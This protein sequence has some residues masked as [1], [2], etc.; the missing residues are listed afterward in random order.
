M[1]RMPL[2][3]G[4]GANMADIGKAYVQIEPTAKGISKKIEGEFSSVG[5]SS[6]AAFSGGFGKVIGG[7]GKVAA[8]AVAAGAGAMGALVTSATKNFGDYEQLVGGVETLFKGS[9]D[10]V[11]ANADRAFASA[12]MSANEYMET[13]TSF[14]ASL[15][16]SLGGDTEKSA[17]YADQA[18]IDMSDNANKMG[19]SID[20]IQD[21]YQGFAK[22]NYTMLDNLKLGYGGTKTEM[23]RLLA[24][25]EKMGGMVEGSLSIDSFADVVQA[26]HI[27]QDNLGITGTTAKE[28]STTIQGSLS[29]M[30]AAWTNLL[31][32]MATD[33]ADISDLVSKLVDSASTF[34]GNL[35]PVVQTAMQ[36]IST[37]IAQIAPV[38][39]QELPA[40]ISSTLPQ[41]LQAG[42]QIIQ[43]LATGILAAIP[44]MLPTITQ[45][46]VQLAQMIIS[47][48]PQLIQ[49]GIEIILALAEGILEAL[50][51]MIP[52]IVTA[53]SQIAQMIITN[54]PTLIELLLPALIQG[55]IMLITML[56][57]E[58]PNIIMAL[59]Q[60]IPQIIQAVVDAIVASAPMFVTAMQTIGTQITT[61]ITTFG[62]QALTNIGTFF[63]N[64]ITNITTWLSQL[65]P[66][67]AYYAGE[68]LAKFVNGIVNLPN[69]LQEIW[70]KILTAIMNFATKFVT[71]GANM[72]KEFGQRLI[73]GLK[74]LPGKVLEIGGQIVEGLK[75]GISSAWSSLTGFV[76]DLA[77]NL[78][79]GFKD[80]LKIGSP[81][82]VFRDEVGRWIP[83]GIAEGITNGMGALNDAVNIATGEIIPNYGIS[84][85]TPST[86][87]TVSDNS[88][89]ALLTQYLPIIAS[90]ENVNVSL[91]VDN[92][93][94]FRIIQT[95][96]RRN[97]QLVGTYA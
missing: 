57:A 17:Q 14:S 2:M 71:E 84:Q 66:K 4:T 55:S 53:V 93:R 24:D 1:I 11:E 86:E 74:E 56:I 70:T 18:I 19:T 10:T 51:Q 33:G 64:L 49:T 92:D 13:V 91:D 95:E 87:Q 96:Q 7:V 54:L 31:T 8:G 68:M 90:G 9:A 79:K 23:E 69:K 88:I 62:G 32:G 63:T 35:M 6:G 81:S 40:L 41:L 89:L 44:Q 21:A 73:D 12:G 28:A 60:A 50:P 22:Q 38:I 30:Q 29:A 82:K 36:G 52:A 85:Y 77:G 61:F 78:V 20:R 48:A 75:N 26:I 72:A 5:A 16:Q 27:V 3:L 37:M 42:L 45:T 59:I 39:A 83:A 34:V 80:N 76:G 15:L 97:T 67:M 94:L 43:T 25:A 58:L 65:P 46:I 47:L